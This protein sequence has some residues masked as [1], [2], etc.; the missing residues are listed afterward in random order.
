MEPCNLVYFSSVS[1]NTH[2]FVQKL[3]LP[4]TRIPLHGRI[5]VD[6]PYVL[7]LPT[8]G[9]A[10]LTRTSIWAPTPAAMS[11]NRSSPF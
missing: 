1:E 6:E 7:I 8:Y 5:E 10:G 11:P 4:A 9:A 3:G 2:R